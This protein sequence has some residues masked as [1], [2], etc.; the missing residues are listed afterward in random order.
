MKVLISILSHIFAVRGH[1]IL[2]IN[3]YLLCFL[4]Y[5]AYFLFCYCLYPFF[6]F[7]RYTFYQTCKLLFLSSV[8]VSYFYRS[9]LKLFG[10]CSLHYHKIAII[11]IVFFHLNSNQTS[12]DGFL[13]AG[14]NNSNIR[15]VS[16][17][18]FFQG[19]HALLQQE[20]WNKNRSRNH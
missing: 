5:I 11:N 6:L 20:N 14:S 13:T 16:N 4:L 15:K 12:G 2:S 7:H 9:T 10:Y 8:F 1:S 19:Y 17:K 18:C 3:M